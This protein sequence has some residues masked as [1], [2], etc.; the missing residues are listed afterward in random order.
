MCRRITELRKLEPPATLTEIAGVAGR[1]P[2]QA[3]RTRSSCR[4]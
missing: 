3:L 4:P 2:R 1:H